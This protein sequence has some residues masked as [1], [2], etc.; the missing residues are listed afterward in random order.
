[1]KLEQVEHDR[2]KACSEAI[3]AA[4]RVERLDAIRHFRFQKKENCWHGLLE[5]VEYCLSCALK[6]GHIISLTILCR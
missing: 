6:R 3:A 1:L 4:G 5:L 2:L